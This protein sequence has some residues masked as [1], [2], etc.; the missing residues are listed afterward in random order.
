MSVAIDKTVEYMFVIS[1]V[2][3]EQAGLLLSSFV[4]E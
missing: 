3:G 2:E 4:Y 1:L